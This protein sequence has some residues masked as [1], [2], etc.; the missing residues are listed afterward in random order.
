MVFRMS[1]SEFSRVPV[2]D[3]A[4]LVNHAPDRALTGEQIG[5]ACRDCGFFYIAGHGVDE[6]LCQQLEVLS[7]RFFLQS[8]SEK[9]RIAMSRGGRAWRGYFPV[10]G[11]LTSGKRD[12]KEASISERNSRRITLRSPP[13]SP[14]MVRTCSRRSPAFAKRC[15]GTLMR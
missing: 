6:L 5:A 1:R 2:I 9:L 4:P 8:E 11:E 13:E 10:G 7:R 3:V 14:C 15:C 12:R